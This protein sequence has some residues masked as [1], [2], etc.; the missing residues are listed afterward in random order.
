M[1]VKRWITAGDGIFF[2]R[3]KITTFYID[4]NF[5]PGFSPVPRCSLLGEGLALYNAPSPAKSQ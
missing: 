2:D 5:L 3:C 1:D 4:R